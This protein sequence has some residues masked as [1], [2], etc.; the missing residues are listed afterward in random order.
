[1]ISYGTEGDL[2]EYPLPNLGSPIGPL[3]DEMQPFSS[4]RAYIQEID[5]LTSGNYYNTLKQKDVD[6]HLY[7]GWKKN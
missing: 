6:I 5:K 3:L 7:A 4:H 2:I 1:M